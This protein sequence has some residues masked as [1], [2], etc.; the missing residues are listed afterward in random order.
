MP[1]LQKQDKLIR[2]PAYLQKAKVVTRDADRARLAD[3]EKP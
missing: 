2:D 1:A 3:L